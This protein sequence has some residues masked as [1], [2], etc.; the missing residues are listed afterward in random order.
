MRPIFLALALHLI[1]ALPA[2]AQGSASRSWNEVKCDRYRAS[3]AEALARFGRAGLGEEFLR[4]HE[5]FIASGCRARGDACPA[6]P[7]ELVMADVMTIA[8]MNAGTASSFVPFVCR[9]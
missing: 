8:A 2:A 3:W 6:S 7:Q 5:A 9:E 1:P 4:R